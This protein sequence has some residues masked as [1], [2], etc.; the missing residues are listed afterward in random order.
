MFIFLNT[1]D[2]KQKIL[3]QAENLV[4]AGYF[5]E[6]SKHSK[7]ALID[8]PRCNLSN[9]PTQ[10]E[11]LKTKKIYI[12]G[13]DRMQSRAEDDTFDFCYPFNSVYSLFEKEDPRIIK[14]YNS[15]KEYELLVRSNFKTII[16]HGLTTNGTPWSDFLK[17]GIYDPRILLLVACFTC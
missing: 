3:T 11:K 4:I 6:Y 10:R 14:N 2:D 12:C 13:A 15:Y 1:S 9:V 8:I 7:C 5:L 16:Q 17:R